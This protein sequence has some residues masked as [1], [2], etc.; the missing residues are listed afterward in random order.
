MTALLLLA[1]MGCSGAGPSSSGASSRASEAGSSTSGP[2]Q[3]GPTESGP[4]E[5]TAP[6]T[7]ADPT[8]P[9]AESG[10][11]DGAGS[12]TRGQPSASSS[13]RSTRPPD[14]RWVFYTDDRTR[15]RSPWFPGAHRVMI[16]F[17]CTPAPYYSPDPRCSGGHGFHHGTDVALPCGTPLRSGVAGTVVSGAALGS[18]YGDRPLLIRTADADV[19][20]AHTRRWRVQV[21]DRIR[22]GQP[23]AW[24]SDA[25]APDGC[26]LHLEVRS[27]G[28]GLSTARD[29]AAV[30]DLEE[31]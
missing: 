31:R 7:T 17:G 5:S 13:P 15:Y 19:L 25:G 30:L 24:A 20:V 11:P 6:P 12:P 3:S 26:H 18:A 8:G 14:P 21:G 28:G 2:T 22:R 4:T 27:P 9:P 23:L 10:A 29:P 1:A 16:P